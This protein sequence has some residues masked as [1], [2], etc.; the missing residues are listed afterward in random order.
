MGAIFLSYRREDSQFATDRIYEHLA[1]K[2]DRKSIFK[3]VDNIPAGVNFKTHIKAAVR[4]SQVMLAIIGPDW[5][6]VN[7]GA[8]RRLDDPDDFVRLEIETALENNV[9]VIPVFVAGASMP[10]KNS[11]PVS[12]RPLVDM[13]GMNV[14]ADPDFI[15]DVKRL[16]VS[17]SVLTQ[18]GEVSGPRWIKVAGAGAAVMVGAGTL[19]WWNAVWPFGGRVQAALDPAT[20]NC[21]DVPFID[22]RNPNVATV[23]RICD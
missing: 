7:N 16:G 12:L 13:A 22:S 15:N 9:P 17:V 8:G 2:F 21:R 4:A 18:G 20:A 5:L 14:R 3:D 11:L 23:R 6:S 19:L 10:A 1:R